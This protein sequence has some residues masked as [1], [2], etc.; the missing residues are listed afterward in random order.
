MI[1]SISYQD[2]VSAITSSNPEQSAG[3]APVEVRQ[4]TMDDVFKWSRLVWGTAISLI[5]AGMLCFWFGFD[6]RQPS[7]D[8]AGHIL[9]AFRFA[10]LFSHPHIL[11]GKWWLDLLMVNNFYPP[12]VYVFNGLLKVFLGPAHYVDWL[13]LAVYD[14]V[15]TGSTFAATLLLTRRLF[16]ATAAAIVVNFYTDMV[17]FSR[18]FLLDFQVAAMIALGLFCL[19]LWNESRTWRRAVFCGIALALVLATKQIAGAFLAGPCLYYC[20][21]IVVARRDHWKE[22]L[23]QLTAMGLISALSMVPWVIASFGFISEFAETN[24]RVITSTA[25]AVTVPEALLRGLWFYAT[26]LPEAVSPML[27]GLL[28][29]ALLFCGD[30]THVRL[31]PALFSALGGV[32]LISMLPWQYPQ[33][34][35]AMGGLVAAAIYT[36]AFLCRC[37]RFKFKPVPVLP[38]VFVVLAATAAFLQY[39]SFCYFPYPFAKPD[40][41]VDFSNGTNQKLAKLGMST[42]GKSNPDPYQD[43]GQKWVLEVIGKR[44]PDLPVWLNVMANHVEYNPHTFSLQAK[45]MDSAVKPTSS[46]T[47]T[48]LGDTV[49]FSEESALYYQWYLIKSGDAGYNLLNA[50]S[51]EANKGILNFV[52]E[53]GKFDLI[54]QKKVPDGSIIFLYRQK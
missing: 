41:M 40:F 2:R 4:P 43:W 48:V 34:R 17:G 30:K 16:A 44:D 22:H 32:V 3:I 7:M 18:T 24:K 51:R 26:H 31:L 10:D 35:Y 21:V 37:W 6:A 50:E 38:K 47:W 33:T 39:F 54:A 27:L 36:G 28:T 12:A 14:L 25:G 15:L 9:C 1:R 42:L 52:R 49:T 19:L 23:A 20:I 5:F 8:E 13:S 53:S 46:R 29:L 45:Y 11:K